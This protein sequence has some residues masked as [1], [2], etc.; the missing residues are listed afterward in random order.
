MLKDLEKNFPENAEMDDSR[1][2][3][4]W[5]PSGP[6][7]GISPS[8]KTAHVQTALWGALVAVLLYLLA[9]L[10][11]TVLHTLKKRA[12]D[13]TAAFE[14]ALDKLAEQPDIDPNKTIFSFES[15]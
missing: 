15:S 9:R 8:F 11:L 10:R 5:E 4:A 12:P 13:V 14:S 1:N 7:G 2:E 6:K 3:H